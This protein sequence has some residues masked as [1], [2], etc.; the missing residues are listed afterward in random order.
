M[1]LRRLFQRKHKAEADRSSLRLGLENDRPPSYTSNVT[2]APAHTLPGRDSVRLSDEPGSS[3]ADT[4][5]V[6]EVSQVVTPNY[7]KRP[8]GNNFSPTSHLCEFC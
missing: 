1:S 4:L 8:S 7:S 6:E 2:T 3:L 5:S